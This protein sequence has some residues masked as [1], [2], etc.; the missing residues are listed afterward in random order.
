METTING[1]RSGAHSEFDSRPAFVTTD[2]Q[3]AALYYTRTKHPF[4]STP[5]LVDF[6]PRECVCDFYF[7]SYVQYSTGLCL[8]RFSSYVPSTPENLARK[9]KLQTTHARSEH[10]AWPHASDQAAN[11]TRP[12]CTRNPCAPPASNGGA[13]FST[14]QYARIHSTFCTAQRNAAFEHAWRMFCAYVLCV[15]FVHMCAMCVCAQRAYVRN[16]PTFENKCL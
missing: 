13:P 1:G 16:V 12:F 4:C 9:I 6:W 10:T 15:C 14:R 3:T 5:H 8:H 11:D 2:A 7:S